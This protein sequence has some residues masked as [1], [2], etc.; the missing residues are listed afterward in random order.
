[1]GFSTL[2]GYWKM[3]GVDF[4]PVF[5][6]STL[7]GKSKHKHSLGKK[8]T[9]KSLQKSRSLNLLPPRPYVLL[10]TFYLDPPPTHITHSKKVNNS[11][12]VKGPNFIFPPEEYLSS[13]WFKGTKIN[14]RIILSFPGI[15]SNYDYVIASVV[16]R[17]AIHENV[18]VIPK[19]SKPEHIGQNIR[20]L[21]L[22]LRPEEIDMINKFDEWMGDLTEREQV[23]DISKWTKDAPKWLLYYTRFF[24]S[25]HIFE[26]SLELL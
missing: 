17:W 12:S 15:A 20:A 18:T 13:K 19:S 11:D 23:E 9:V 8:F 3:L 2:G 1:M 25:N 4:N 5:T 26:L 14:L 21:D 24:I 7:T 10:V 16:L 22:S 6:S